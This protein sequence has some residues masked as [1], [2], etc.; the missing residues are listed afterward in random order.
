[1]TD[2]PNKSTKQNERTKSHLKKAFISL[3]DEKGYSHVS[4]TDIIKRAEYN[5]TTF[6]LHYR[7]KQDLTEELRQEMFDAIKNASINRYVK[8]KNIHI[9]NMGPQSFEL[10]HF[11]YKNQDFFNLYLKNDTI[12]GLYKDL[13]QAIY[14]VLE[15]SFI[16]TAVN[17]SDINYSAHKLYMANGTA[18]LILEWIKNGYRMTADEMSMQLIHILQSFAKDFSIVS[19]HRS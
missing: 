16:L 11:I 4:V 2:Q 12:P 8:G 7:D 15:E 17:K 18:G 14:E 1:M 19:K 5:R 9:T 13:P 6:Y 3:V 10:M